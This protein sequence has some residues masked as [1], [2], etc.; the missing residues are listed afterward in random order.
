MTSYPTN[1][2]RIT[3]IFNCFVEFVIDWMIRGFQFDLNEAMIWKGSK[4]GHACS[5]FELN[6]ACRFSPFFSRPR[7]CRSFRARKAHQ[8]PR[9]H[10]LRRLNQPGQGHLIQKLSP[11]QRL[12][13]GFQKWQGNV[14]RCRGSNFTIGQ[15][16]IGH[17]RVPLCLCF[18]ASL[19]AKPLLWKW[20]WFAWKWNYMQ[21]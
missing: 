20:L 8:T 16:V 5:L 4:I 10:Q 14:L 7:L 21:N 18:K 19:S 15:H 17:F 6:E 11:P 12:H 3:L 1:A 13:S 9:K 2:N